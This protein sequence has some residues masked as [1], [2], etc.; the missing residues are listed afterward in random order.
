MN[1]LIAVL[2]VRDVR[3]RNARRW[4]EA[5]VHVRACA[6]AWTHAPSAAKPEQPDEGVD[7]GA[8][9]A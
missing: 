1:V 3:E 7:C 4:E 9:G 6:D 2:L 5:C 8:A